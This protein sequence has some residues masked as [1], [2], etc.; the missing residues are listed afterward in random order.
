M[1][2][3]YVSVH[4]RRP[5]GAPRGGLPDPSPARPRRGRYGGLRRRRPAAAR[6][7]PGR[8]GRLRHLCRHLRPPLRLHPRPRQ[9]RWASITE[10]EYRHAQALDIPRLV[11]LLDPAAPWP[12]TWID[13]F[14]GDGDGGARIRTLREELGR[15][16]LASFFATADELA[17]EGQR[18]HHQPAQAI[19]WSRICRRSRPDGH[20]RSRRRC[21]PSPAGSSSWPCCTPS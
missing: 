11:F 1:A 15:D 9:P 12:P 20:G 13:A 16:R 18:G 21:A 10:L 5:Q 2:R 14:T 17:H 8:C 3:I 6:P 19:S 4:L 7:V